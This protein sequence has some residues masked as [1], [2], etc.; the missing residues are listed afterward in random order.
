M[1]FDGI[2]ADID[3]YKLSEEDNLHDAEE[4]TKLM[5]GELDTP[6]H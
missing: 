1:Y 3:P 6:Y 4:D 2:G 5:L